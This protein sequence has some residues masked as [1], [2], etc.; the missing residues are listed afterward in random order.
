MDAAGHLYSK[1]DGSLL[2]DAEDAPKDKPAQPATGADNP[3]IETPAHQE[4]RVPAGVGGRGDD[5]TRVGSDIPDPAR[6]GDNAGHGSTRRVTTPPRGAPATTVPRAAT[7][8]TTCP[9]TA[10]LR[11]LAGAPHTPRSPAGWTTPRA[12]LATPTKQA[13][14]ATVATASATARPSRTRATAPPPATSLPPAGT[15]AAPVPA[16][17]ML[18]R[19]AGT[20]MAPPTVTATGT[21]QADTTA[22][23][24]TTLGANLTRLHTTE[25]EVVTTTAGVPKVALGTGRTAAATPPPTG[26]TESASPA[27]VRTSRFRR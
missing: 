19:P 1:D 14:R 7:R 18:R 12:A 11:A 24:P 5:V 15:A 4:Q 6:T 16:G 17:T 10:T 20:A 26:P 23:Q 21:A 9:Q 25:Q 3:R 22:H 27:S 8:A 13:A 2:Q